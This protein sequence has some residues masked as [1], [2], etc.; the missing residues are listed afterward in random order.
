MHANKHH[1]PRACAW[2]SSR[3][4]RNAARR[5]SNSPSYPCRRGAAGCGLPGPRC[6][7][8]SR[9]R[10]AVSTLVCADRPRHNKP[11]V[12]TRDLLTG[13]AVADACPR[14][15]AKLWVRK[16]A[17]VRQWRRACIA[18]RI[19]RQRPEHAVGRFIFP[20]TAIELED[21]SY[22]FDVA[23]SNGRNQPR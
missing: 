4:H 18:Y 11:A 15:H 17:A 21:R 9:D 16:R 13:L 12:R 22:S 19:C 14:G 7:R 6:S 10:R 20:W 5:R 3:A 2:E 1:P 23:D 8:E